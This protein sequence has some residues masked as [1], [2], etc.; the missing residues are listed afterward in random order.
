MRS[1]V[2]FLALAIYLSAGVYAFAASSIASV[3][4]SG[5]DYV[6]LSDWARNDGMK[7]RSLNREAVELSNGSTTFVFK[8]D[9]RE[10]RANGVNVWLSMPAIFRDGSVHVSRLDLQSTLRPLMSPPKNSP[11]V[12]L[13]SVCLDPGHGGVDPGK[14]V[15]PFQ[16]K[17]FTLLLA[18]EVRQ[19]L[20]RSGLRVTI[21]RSKDASLDL[22]S[23]PECAKRNRADLFV[24]LHFNSVQ[25]CRTVVRGA[26]V[27]CL[28]PPGVGSTNSRD[29]VSDAGWCP[30]NRNNNKNIYLAYQVQ[31]AL[32]QNPL[33]ND[34]GVRRA[35][36]AVLRDAEM[37][38]VLIEAAYMSHP[39]EGKRIFDAG[40]RKQLA[41]TIADGVLAYKRAVEQKG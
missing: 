5:K 41:K 22:P 1:R 34:R 24:S 15:G 30:G 13:K 40:Y 12:E 21:T 11:G 37:P 25:S 31:K 7:L 17:K 35:R 38:A 27:Y 8:A 16:E 28:T 4:L 18:Q 10:A 23:R 19:L 39:E 29:D 6:R 3:K 14:C 36:F 32:T 26:E 2:L 20:T 33:T 9:S